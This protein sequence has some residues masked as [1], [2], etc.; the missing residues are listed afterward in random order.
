MVCVGLVMVRV[1]LVMVRVVLVVG[2]FCGGLVSV[3]DG[4]LTFVIV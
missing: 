2:C 4:F 1:V 3:G